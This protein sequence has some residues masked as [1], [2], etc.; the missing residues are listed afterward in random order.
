MT[1]LD[2]YHVSREP[3]QVLTKDQIRR[4]LTEVRHDPVTFAPTAKHAAVAMVIADG[5]TGL[6]VCFIRRAEQDGDPWS[7][8]VSFP[9]GRAETTD[10][11]A[12]AVAE[13]ET[14]EEFGL[15]LGDSQRIGNLPLMPRI[16][17]GLTL[18]PFV[19]FAD[20]MTR[21]QAIVRTPEEVASVFWIP[22]T[23]LFDPGA[24]TQLEYSMDG[25]MVTLPGIRFADHVIWGLTLQ[26]LQSFASLVKRPF[27]AFD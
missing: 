5:P 18:F 12:H 13:R 7:G 22:M 3:V 24:V 1:G 8:H 21:A 9:G 6:D 15:T 16:R 26:L 19:Y 27:P 2:R 17:H 25:D 23:H 20:N 11:S 10:V 14:Y 4:A